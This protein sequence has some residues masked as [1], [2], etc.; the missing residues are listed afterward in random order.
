MTMIVERWYRYPRCGQT[1]DINQS[2][3]NQKLVALK[4]TPWS[5]VEQLYLEQYLA[6]PSL[7]ARHLEIRG[8][9]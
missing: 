7:R 8:R 1:T 9:R 3:S 6:T 5:L 4:L 2:T